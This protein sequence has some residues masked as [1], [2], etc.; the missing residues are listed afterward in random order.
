VGPIAAR[1]GGQG[2]EGR[3]EGKEKKGE[4]R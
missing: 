3:R 2:G 1:R 4:A